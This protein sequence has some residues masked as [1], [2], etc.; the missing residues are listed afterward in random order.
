MI[1]PADESGFSNRFRQLLYIYLL[2]I[3]TIKHVR[4][5]VL[6]LS[7]ALKPSLGQIEASEMQCHCKTNQKTKLIQCIS[8]LVQACIY[9]T[10]ESC[11]FCEVSLWTVAQLLGELSDLLQIFI[12]LDLV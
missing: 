6:C 4:P 2:N 9:L 5:T 11:L 7:F 8:S 1:I 3:N 12:F 10:I